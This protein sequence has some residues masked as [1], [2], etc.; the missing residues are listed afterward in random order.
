M[1]GGYLCQDGS[2]V[3]DL[4]Q[5]T[6]ERHITRIKALLTGADPT[7]RATFEAFLTSLRK[8]LNPSVSKDDG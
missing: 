7:H 3:T 8:N 6:A 1:A 2:A 4:G 5:R